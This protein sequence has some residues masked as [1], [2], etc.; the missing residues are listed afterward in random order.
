MVKIK[1]PIANKVKEDIKTLKVEI[2]EKISA[3]VTAG[4]GLV[5][6]LAW[7]DAIKALFT[8]LFPEPGGN[9]FASFTYALLITIIIVI[10]TIQL[11]RMIDLAKKPLIKDKKNNE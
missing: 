6:A 3:L 11:G 4:L 2:L 10:I 5:A 9:I 8:K 1:P 7:N